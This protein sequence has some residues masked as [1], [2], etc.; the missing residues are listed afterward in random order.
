MTPKHEHALDSVPVFLLGFK[1]QLHN[2]G[3]EFTINL[4]GSAVRRK[5]RTP[6]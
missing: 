6:A 1:F 2:V 3:Q 5:P 4:D